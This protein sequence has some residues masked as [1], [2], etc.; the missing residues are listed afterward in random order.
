M[1]S[2][3]PNDGPLFGSSVS[4]LS[5][6][7]HRVISPS[8]DGVNRPKRLKKAAP[9][10]AV[11]GLFGLKGHTREDAQRDGQTGETGND[12]L[13]RMTLKVSGD[14]GDVGDT[15][16]NSLS[17]VG[18]EVSPLVEVGAVT[19]GDTPAEHEIL[20]LEVRYLADLPLPTTLTLDVPGVGIVLLSTSKARVESE[21]Q[22]GARIWAPLGFELAAYAFH[23]G[24]ARPSDWQAWCGRL[25]TPGWKLTEAEAFGGAA[26]IEGDWRA[27]RRPPGPVPPSPSPAS[28]GHRRPQ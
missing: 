24:R 26:G 1:A 16:T 6:G 23:V 5:P 19:G 18:D 12:S 15:D 27:A 3:R 10:T 2:P 22:A 17:N 11:T 25:A 13:A 4:P 20:S 21:R 7:G 8:G 14:T 9:V 28:R